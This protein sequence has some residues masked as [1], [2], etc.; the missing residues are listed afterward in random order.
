MPSLRQRVVESP[1][2]LTVPRWSYDPHFD[3]NFHLSRAAAP[4]PGTRDAVLELAR[5][6]AMAAFDLA[7]PLWEVTLVE[8]IEGGEAALI[9]KLHHALSDGVRAMRMLATVADA[10]REPADLGEMPPVRPD[11]TPDLPG[12]VVGTVG[13]MAGRAASLAW[14]GTA[15]AIPALIRYTRDPVGQARGAVAMARSVYRT[16]APNSAALSPLMRERAMTRHLAM[17]EVSLD[18]LKKAAKTA[19]GT[20]NDAYLAAIAGGLAGTTNGTTRPSSPCGP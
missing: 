4:P 18:A 13:S 20:V 17:I 9:V 1:L 5:R 12:L 6:A 14:L 16:A 11:E 19:E 10:Q 7:R 3:L 2:G 15:A 8:G